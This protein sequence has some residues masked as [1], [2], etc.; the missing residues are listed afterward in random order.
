M[1]LFDDWFFP[2]LIGTTF[3]LIGSLKLYGLRRAIVGG[4][5]KPLMTKLSGT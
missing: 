4:P 2:V 1:I 3:I 5:K